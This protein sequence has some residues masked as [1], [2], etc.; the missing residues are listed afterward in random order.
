MSESERY[1]GSCLCGTVGVSVRPDTRHVDACHCSMCRK[2]G[3][4]PLFVLDATTDVRFRGEAEISIYDSSEWAERGF[5]RHC[6][7]HLFYR[8]KG[9][10]EY[11]VPV[12]LI[13]GDAEWQFTKQIFVDEQPAYYRIAN[14]TP[15]LTGAEVFAQYGA[16]PG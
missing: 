15:R 1:D 9:S 3:G 13:D 10:G 2:W 5:C 6:G 8:L 14:D 11:A 16:D 4:G 7:T 12:D